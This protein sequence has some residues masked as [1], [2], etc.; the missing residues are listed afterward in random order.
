MPYLDI[1]KVV[2]LVN[3]FISLA[4]VGEVVPRNDGVDIRLPV[5]APG[6]YVRIITSDTRGNVI[7]SSGCQS[8]TILSSDIRYIVY[9]DD[10]EWVGLR[11]SGGI[12]EL[13][14]RVYGSGIEPLEY[15]VSDPR[16]VFNVVWLYTGGGVFYII[17]T[18]KTSWRQVYPIC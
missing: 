16:A 18:E 13:L 8:S 17:I 7:M 6:R 14:V 2:E 1:N 4:G 5:V 9:G 15:S 10:N 12:E 11:V 3:K